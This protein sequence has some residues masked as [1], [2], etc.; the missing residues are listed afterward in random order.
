MVIW[1]IGAQ[2]ANAAFDAIALYPIGQETRWGDW[3]KQWAKDDLDRLGFPQRFRF[4][5]SGGRHWPYEP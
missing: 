3:A 1:L 5:C 4:P 2:A